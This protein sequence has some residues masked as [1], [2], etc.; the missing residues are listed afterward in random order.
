MRTKKIIIPL[1]SFL[2]FMQSC[3]GKGDS[4]FDYRD[5]DAS[6]TAVFSIGSD[7]PIT[8][9]G[10]RSGDNITL[11]ITSPE[12]SSDV[13]VLYDYSTVYISAGET[14]IPLSSDASGDMKL[15]FDILFPTPESLG[16]WT[17]QRSDDGSETI[18]T[19]TSGQVILGDD[20]LPKSV[21]LSDDRT[22]EITGYCLVQ[23]ETTPTERK[24][25]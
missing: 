20:L 22:I 4:V 6:F 24:Q 1:I 25:Q 8:C 21:I 10:E 15:F 3:G 11:R 13:S 14:I 12:R 9:S 23:A 18:L 5:H 17:A 16:S 2:L 7:V 19:G